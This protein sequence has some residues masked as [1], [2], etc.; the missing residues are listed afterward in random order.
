MKITST[1]YRSEGRGVNKTDDMVR[2]TVDAK[3][4]R[5][6]D[7]VKAALSAIAD[8]CSPHA[9][10]LGKLGGKAKSPAKT[11]TARANGRKGGRPKNKVKLPEVEG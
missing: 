2:I 4:G 11:A 3:A 7:M 10:A 9:A 5:E 6:A 8:S 1:T